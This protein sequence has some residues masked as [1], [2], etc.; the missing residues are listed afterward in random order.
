MAM[1]VTMVS[2]RMSWASAAAFLFGCASGGGESGETHF[3]CAATPDC[4]VHG[5]GYAC[6]NGICRSG[7]GGAGTAAGAGAGGSV[8]GG[9]SA[10]V[11]SG[12]DPGRDPDAST[13]R[14]RAAVTFNIGPSP[15][16]LCR[17]TNGQLS[18]PAAQNASVF[19]DLLACT[20]G[21]GCKPDEFVVE[22]RDRGTT[23]SCMVAPSGSN[24]TVSATLN[25][26]GSPSMQFQANGVL[27]PSGG[28]LSINES[29]SEA[30]GGGSDPACSVQLLP[31]MSFLESGKIWAQFQCSNF[32]DP[33]DL[34]DTGCTVTGAFLFENCQG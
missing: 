32:R 3:V 8:G 30:M 25:V 16:N 1:R 19:G 12:G 4:A 14:Q 22:D 34:S 2:S 13:I 20:L 7:D 28:T 24:F 10:G 26:D 15:G 18:M 11:A 31:D 23:I 17:H 21:S 33:N 29:N 6:V 5:A 27:S 9:G